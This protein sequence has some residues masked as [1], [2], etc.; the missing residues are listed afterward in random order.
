MVSV[1]S[2]MVTQG[3]AINGALAVSI[4]LWTGMV[5]G[6]LLPAASVTAAMIFGCELTTTRGSLTQG[7][8]VMVMW[9]LALMVFL[10]PL[11]IWLL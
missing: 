2:M 5:T 11:G 6:Y 10:I 3:L 7:V 4:V 8:I 1:V 9:L